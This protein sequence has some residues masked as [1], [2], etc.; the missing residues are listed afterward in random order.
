MEEISSSFMV[1]I[2]TVD[3]SQSF[4]KYKSVRHI[5]KDVSYRKCLE[6]AKNYPHNLIISADTVVVMDK[7]IIGKPKDQE[8][9]FNILK[10]LSNRHHYVYT[11]YTLKKGDILV[12]NIVKSTVYFNSLSDDLIHRYVATSSP[13]DKAGAYGL[14][15]NDHFP[16]IKKVVGSPTNVIGFPLEE[17]KRDLQKYFTTAEDLD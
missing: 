12:Q 5:V 17:I 7:E 4:K 1:V 11:A 16:I 9:A 3:E 13:M 6:V 10:K 15:D 2:P 8:E 14:Q